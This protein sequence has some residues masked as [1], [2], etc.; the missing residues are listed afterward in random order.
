M[1][2]TKKTTSKAINLLVEGGKLSV[3][4]DVDNDTYKNVHLTGPAD[5]VF[6]GIISI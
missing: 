2:K 6:N 3:S 4:F 1:H 5:F